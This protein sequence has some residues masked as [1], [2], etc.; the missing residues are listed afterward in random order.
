MDDQRGEVTTNQNRPSND[1]EDSRA[2]PF[3]PQIPDGEHLAAPTQQFVIKL[4]DLKFLDMR[5]GL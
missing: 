5:G 1:F 4:R 2:R 3:W